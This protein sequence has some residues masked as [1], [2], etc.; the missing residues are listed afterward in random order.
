MDDKLNIALRPQ[1]LDEY[2]GQDEVK[3]ILIPAMQ[4][5]K[6][7]GDP[8]DHV[9]LTGG[10]GLGKT[11]LAAIIAKEMNTAFYSYMGTLMKSPKDIYSTFFRIK[12]DGGGTVFIDEIHRVWIPI[13]ELLYPLLEDR[14]LV[15]KIGSASSNMDVPGFTMIGAT[16]LPQKLDQ[17]FKDR[18]PLKF[19][20]QPF[21]DEQLAMVVRASAKKLELNIDDEAIMEV[22]K[23]ARKT[24]RV[25]NNLLRRI[26]DF[27][28]VQ[29]TPE[30]NGA[31]ANQIL[32]QKGLVLASG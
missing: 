26:R 29:H 18:F 7:R 22:V 11:T 8:L 32:S 28:I 30:V 25:A 1:T 17:P 12:V 21:S 6:E 19:T 31:F 13:R 3:Q 15:Y 2:V 5:A 10:P 14:I 9:L 23:R 27:S 24:P 4:A 20:L 16:T